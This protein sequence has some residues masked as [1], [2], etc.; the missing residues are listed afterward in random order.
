MFPIPEGMDEFYYDEDRLGP[1]L[2]QDELDALTGAPAAFGDEIAVEFPDVTD[3]TG[4]PDSPQIFGI[5]EQ[6]IRFLPDGTQLVD[7]IFSV[8]DVPGANTYELAVA[9]I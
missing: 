4:V 3:Y 9:P 1:E 7:V 6:R 8:E 5:L 2:Q